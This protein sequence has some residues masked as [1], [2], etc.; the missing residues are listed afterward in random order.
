MKYQKYNF[1]NLQVYDLYYLKNQELETINPK[2]DELF[3][4]LS[5]LRKSLL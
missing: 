4:K 2:I 3:F 5:A 1:E